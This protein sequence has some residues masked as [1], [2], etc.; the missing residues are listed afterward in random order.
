MNL[1]C[2]DLNKPPLGPLVPDIDFKFISCRG[3]ALGSPVDSGEDEV[4]DFGLSRSD[5]LHRSKASG[6]SII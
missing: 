3:G 1:N 5:A 6:W 4:L 2:P